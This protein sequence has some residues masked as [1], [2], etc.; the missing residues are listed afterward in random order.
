MKK[1]VTHRKVASMLALTVFALAA[2]VVAG[3][4]SAAG[5]AS[6]AQYQYG[7][8]VN[9]AAPTVS[10]APEVG[11]TLTAND[12]TWTSTTPVTYSLQWV[13]CDAQGAN[14]AAIAGATAQTY[15]VKATDVGRRIAVSVTAKNTN[16]STTA[17]SAATAP[18]AYPSGK[19]IQAST[20]ALPDRLVVD[21]VEYS[22]NPIRSR[23]TPTQMRVHVS[24]AH[25]NSVAGSLVYVVGIPYSRIGVMP[26]VQTDSA[27]WA[28]LSLRPDRFFPRTGYLVL[29]VRARVSGQDAL[30]GTSTRRLVQV[31]IAA[32]SS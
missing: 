21:K 4:G 14:C 1:H 18:A 27:G 25:G 31:T 9:T 19:S 28:T 13:S 22:A 5:N 10:G 2:V 12:G 17:Q 20:V 3:S 29:F 16:G 23:L 26:E 30:G 15:V 8:P 24:D 32:P 6:S 11:Q 7:A